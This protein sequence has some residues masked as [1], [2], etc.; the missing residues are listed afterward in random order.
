MIKKFII[1]CTS[2]EPEVIGEELARNLQ[3]IQ[4][5]KNTHQEH[6]YI[7]TGRTAELNAGKRRNF[8]FIITKAKE[9]I[10]S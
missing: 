9:W 4:M 6:D 8:K 1:Q 3:T 10:A 2:Q 7:K 5:N